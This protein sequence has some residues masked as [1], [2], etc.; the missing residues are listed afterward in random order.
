[1]AAEPGHDPGVTISQIIDTSAH[2]F[3]RLTVTLVPEP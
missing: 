1:M 3:L 2:R